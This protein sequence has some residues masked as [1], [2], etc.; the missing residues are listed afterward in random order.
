MKRADKHYYLARAEDELERAK[1]ADHP[2][3]SRSHYLLAR[4][5]LDCAHRETRQAPR[6]P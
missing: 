5:Y 6:E 2:R 1:R 4:L 3:A